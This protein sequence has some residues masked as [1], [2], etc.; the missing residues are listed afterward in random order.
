M[1]VR[2]IFWCALSGLLVLEVSKGADLGAMLV[3]CELCVRLGANVKATPLL[4]HQRILKVWRP[5]FCIC[6]CYCT[7]MLEEV[8][9]A[10]WVLLLFMFASICEPSG[11]SVGESVVFFGAAFHLL[12]CLGANGGALLRGAGAALDLQSLQELHSARAHRTTLQCAAD[13]NGL[14]HA[15]FFRNLCA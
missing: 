9:R 5:K 3:T 15:T 13:S 6:R 2:L 7:D 8:S 11:K 12:S 10:T 14:P 4:E 1:C